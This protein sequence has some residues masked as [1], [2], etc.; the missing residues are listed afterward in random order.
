MPSNEA[1]RRWASI[2][3]QG[4][5]AWRTCSATRQGPSFSA[6]EIPG[7]SASHAARLDDSGSGSSSTC[8]RFSTSTRTAQ[9]RAAADRRADDVGQAGAGPTRKGETDRGQGRPR[10]LGPLAV[11]AGQAG[12]LLD[13]RPTSALRFPAG[14]LAGE[15]RVDVDVLTVLQEDPEDHPEHAEV[16]EQAVVRRVC[17]DLVKE[18]GP[19][20]EIVRSVSS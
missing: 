19:Y 10:S 2:E 12:Y 20:F 5:V 15:E 6:F 4:G 3:L 8:L 11:P 16:V 14:E 9:D 1:D 18:F 17:G 13:E 7:R